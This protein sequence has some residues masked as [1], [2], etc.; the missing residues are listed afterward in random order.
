MS[1]VWLDSPQTEILTLLTNETSVKTLQKMWQMAPIWLTLLEDPVR[2]N[3]ADWP[4]NLGDSN[5]AVK[6]T[7]L[8]PN[9]YG[10]IVAD[11]NIKQNILSFFYNLL[12]HSTLHTDVYQTIKAR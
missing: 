3:M 5:K 2:G 8:Q 6:L 9:I 1:R 12:F 11:N 4:E 7:S 10:E